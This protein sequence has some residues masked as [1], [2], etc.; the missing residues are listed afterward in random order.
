MARRADGA[1]EPLPRRLYGADT[2]AIRR[3]YKGGGGHGH[4]GLPASTIWAPTERPEESRDREGPAARDQDEAQHRRLR[5]TRETATPRVGRCRGPPNPRAVRIAVSSRRC[6]NRPSDRPDRGPGTTRRSAGL[7]YIHDARQG[8]P[9]V[10]RCSGRHPVRATES[11]IACPVS[12]RLCRFLRHRVLSH[13]QF[14]ALPSCGGRRHRLP[15]VSG[16]TSHRRSPPV[17]ASSSRSP[18][19]CTPPTFAAFAGAPPDR[20]PR[21]SGTLRI[22]R[23]DPDE[24]RRRRPGSDGRRSRARGGVPADVDHI[25]DELKRMCIRSD[26]LGITPYLAPTGRVRAGN[27]GR[28]TRLFQSVLT[29]TLDKTSCYTLP[30]TRC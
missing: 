21:L 9:A 19:S 4:G 24:F 12:C 28:I 8:V 14:L 13:H 30:V 17:R 2:S 27:R 1:G 23:T 6:A 16:A 18:R 20:R 26:L 25:A 29:K 11:T 15:P 5:M 3:R 10:D 22:A 7:E